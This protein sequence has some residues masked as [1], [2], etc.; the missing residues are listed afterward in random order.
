MWND[1]TEPYKHTIRAFLIFFQNEILRNCRT[2]FD[3]RNGSVGNFFFAGARLFFHSLEAAIFLFSRVTRI[4]EG[5]KVLPA[6][7]TEERITLGAQLQNGLFIRG[8]SQI[9]HPQGS[10]VHIVDKQC[11]GGP[12][13][14]AIH[15]VF[16]LASEGTGVEHEVQFE[17]NRSV[18]TALE[19][20]DMIVY[21]MGSLYTS[22]CSTLILR[23]IGEVISEKSCPKVLLLNGG[24][25]RETYLCRSSQIS[26]PMSATD[27]LEAVVDAL[28]R[29]SCERLENPVDRYVTTILFPRNGQMDIDRT[30]LEVTGI[31][32]VIEVDSVTDHKGAVRYR[33]D[34]LVQTLTE[35]SERPWT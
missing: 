2:H 14:A 7:Q 26:G 6:I 22:I 17:A 35:I 15:R 29:I 25:D 9:S 11:D 8:Q 5:S 18:L 19:Q 13:P 12:L 28:N 10:N 32:S 1:V 16:Y 20:A 21:G 33:P 24:H 3:F 34:A 4:P 27:V 23:G 31:R 30:E